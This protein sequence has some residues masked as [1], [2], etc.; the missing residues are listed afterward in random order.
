MLEVGGQPRLGE[1]AQREFWWV[2]ILPLDLLATGI[3]SLCEYLSSYTHWSLCTL[4]YMSHV[5]NLRNMSA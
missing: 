2:D 1:G 4:L 5:P 3:C